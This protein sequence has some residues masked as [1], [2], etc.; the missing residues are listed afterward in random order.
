MSKTRA[1]AW[2]GGL[3]RGA[4]ALAVLS[5]LAC[6]ADESRLVF[7]E[8]P[9]QPGEPPPPDEAEG[10]PLYAMLTQIITPD[11]DRTVYIYL[12]TSLDIAE[13]DLSQ[14]RE[15]AGVTNFNAVGG[16]I[17]VS[18]GQAPTITEFEITPDL[19]WIEGRT[20]GFDRYPLTD[21][22]NWY[23]QFVRDDHTAYLPYDGYKRV[24]WDPTDMVILGD[25]EDTT[26]VPQMGSLLLE[27]GGNRNGLR[28]DGSVYQSFFWRDE[29]WFQF[30]SES[31]IVSYDPVTH[32]ESS[33]LT[34]PCAG[35][36]IATAD[37]AGYTYFGS[38]DYLPGLA[39]YGEG[40]APC[41]ARLTPDGELDEGW[42]SDFT[43]LT[44]GRY[45]T[46]FR[47]VGGGR[48]VANVFHAEEMDVDFSQPMDPEVVSNLWMS[49]PQWRFWSFDLN[50]Q[51]A[52]PVEGVTVEIG[53]S[54]QFAVLDGR[55]FV[56]LP[57][58]DQARSKIYEIDEAGVAVEHLDAP[59][60]VFKWI[61]VR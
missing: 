31:V 32:A 53:S 18:S 52:Q 15:Y 12:S 8:D 55:T 6:G 33:K 60:D 34:V 58:G 61:R 54:A 22:A 9:L 39:L 59:G 11:D 48:A 13:V 51:T 2:Y 35:L 7:A 38:W 5:S 44:G 37:E 56:F 20:V 41:A 45:I 46:N 49:G 43:Q 1:F 17:L 28:V 26:L 40:P 16:R 14:A 21:N 3:T 29:D 4:A 30:G 57:Y 19:Q 25:R 36:A 23:Y 24:V 50:A 47:Y 10:P 27:A 42:T